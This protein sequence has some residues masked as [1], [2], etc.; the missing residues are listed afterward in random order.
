MAL[1]SISIPNLISGVSQQADALRFASQAEESINAYPSLVDGLVKRPCTNHIAPLF[2]EDTTGAK[3]HTINRDSGERYTVVFNPNDAVRV[4]DMNGVEKTVITR[5]DAFDY[6]PATANVDLKCLSVADFT[7]VLNKQKTAQEYANLT[8][9]R[10]YEAMIFVSQGAYSAEYSVTINGTKYTVM[11][12]DGNTDYVTTSPA[13]GKGYSWV[14]NGT[15]PTETTWPEKESASTAKIA[16]FLAAAIRTNASFNQTTP[17]ASVIQ[18]GSS[19]YIKRND[20]AAFS[21]AVSD[22]QSGTGLKL[23]NE[24]VQSFLDLPA[25]GKHGFIVK[26]AGEPDDEGDEYWVKFDASNGSEGTGVWKETVQ[27]GIKFALDE[28][29]L[30]HALIRLQNGSFLFT[31]LDG[32]TYTAPGN[33]FTYEIPYWGE[34]L[35]G[36]E[37]SNPSASFVDRK[38]KDILFFRNRLGF[39][40]DENVILSEASEFFN[41]YRTTVTQL[42]D[43]DPIDVASSS[44]KVSILFAGIPFN[45]KLLLFSDQ[46]QFS[47]QSADNLTSKTVSIQ[48]TTNFACSTSSQPVAV[49]KNIYFAFDRDSFSGIQ[50]YY[51]NPESQYLDGVDISASIPSYIKGTVSKIVGSDNEQMIVVMSSGLK[52]G[53]YMYKYFFNGSEKLQSAWCKFTI[54]SDP[55]DPNASSGLTFIEN[56]DFIDNKLYVVTTRVDGTYLERIDFQSNKSDATSIY[57]VLL[58]RKVSSAAVTKSFDSNTGLTTFTLPYGIDP[59]KAAVITRATAPSGP[60]Y[61]PQSVGGGPGQLPIT[62]GVGGGVVPVN[63]VDNFLLTV[64]GNYSA[65]PLWIGENY[66]MEHTLGRVV[67]R[68]PGSRGN[69]TVVSVGKLYLR[70]ASLS[71]DKT[72]T[73]KVR[74]IPI[75]NVYPTTYEYICNNQAAGTTTAAVNF[76]SLRDGTFRFPILSKNDQVIIKLVNDSPHPCSILSLDVEAQ[77]VSRSQRAG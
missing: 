12:G 69:P 18:I 23:I 38:I 77:Y 54:G 75:N 32:D 36:D 35:V 16:Q 25:E 62:T 21:I 13:G 42:L 22:S 33:A 31:A 6:I 65:V 2:F 40:C 60:G 63:S 52:N 64:K 73:F 29:T 1:V 51:L 17:T 30:P 50:E 9:S 55:D 48:N 37:D 44:N 19:V 27:P 67:I 14:S 8:P 20:N 61:V 68:A 66:T 49:G 7:L 43:S 57:S 56:V 58:D 34:R 15:Q 39:L 70:R 4:W 45:E 26:V 11:T 41:F 72:R 74:V 53:F 28:E 46:T 76:D 24:E 47:L 3:W 10:P 59:A 5:N 71:Y